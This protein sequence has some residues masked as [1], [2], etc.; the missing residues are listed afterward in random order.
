LEHV[1]TPSVAVSDPTGAGD[2]FCGAYAACRLLGM[3]P[4]EAARR[5]VISAALVVGCSGVE[6]ALATQPT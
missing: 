4:D 1:P 6:A 2:S 5:A 3:P